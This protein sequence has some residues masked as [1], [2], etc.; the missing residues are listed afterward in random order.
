MIRLEKVSCIYRRGT[1]L[2]LTALKETSVTVNPGEYIMVVGSNGS[3]K[4]TLLNLLSGHVRAASGKIFID[5]KDISE[6][7]EFKRSMLFAHVFQNPLSGTAPGLSI[8]ENFR[9]AALRTGRRKLIVGN[10]KTFRKVV[11]HEISRLQL[12]LESN[13]D[14]LM[15]SLSGGQRQALTLLMAV[16]SPCKV[17]LLDE[18]SAALD[19][20]T[21]EMVMRIADD[22]IKQHQL[23]AIHITH[24]MKDAAR[25]GNRLWMMEEGRITR[26]IGGTEK[27]NL[28][29]PEL[30]SWFS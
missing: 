1:S 8:V 3:G 6:L 15:G 13:P 5:K 18:P 23:T 26:D 4:S 10:N 11:Q 7:P 16:M 14:R 12:G 27:E 24:N 9:L 20:R 2:E 19:P 29:A 22:L 28:T 17:L 25:Y 21:S 30:F